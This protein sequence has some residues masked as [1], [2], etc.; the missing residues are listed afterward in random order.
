LILKAMAG[1]TPSKEWYQSRL[2]DLS[3]A[4]GQI[5][6][7]LEPS[8]LGGVLAHVRRVAE[9]K[10]EE[11]DEPVWEPTRLTRI[12]STL[13]PFMALPDGVSDYE[14]SRLQICES[15]PQLLCEGT[16]TGL[17][18]V[19]LGA[20]MFGMSAMPRYSPTA[21]TGIVNFVYCAVGREWICLM[22][23]ETLSFLRGQ[24]P[25][26]S[27]VSRRKGAYRH[28]TELL[29]S[30]R[31][32][33]EQAM[34]ALTVAGVAKHQFGTLR[35]RTLHVVATDMLLRSRG[36]IKNALAELPHVEPFYVS[37]QYS[38]GRFL[39]PSIERFQKLWQSWKA[40]L[41]YILMEA[42]PDL[43]ETQQTL[44]VTALDTLK[45]I[46]P[47]SMFARGLQYSLVYE[48]AW[49]LVQFSESPELMAIYFRRLSYL[50]H[51]V[52]Y[53]GGSGMPEIEL[54]GVVYAAI[55]SRARRD[56]LFEHCPE[57]VADS[58]AD[59][60]GM[61]I[62][63]LK[64]YQYLDQS[65]CEVVLCK[66]VCWLRGGKSAFSAEEWARLKAQVFEEWEHMNS[67]WET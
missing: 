51:G 14:K 21:A 44:V 1:V 50:S 59:I 49:T 9:T 61:L 30:H 55:V 48:L 41:E 29:Q 18:T 28:L 22:V 31:S 19:D 12:Q 24:D 20:A 3:A 36:T 11:F 13:D 53:G 10:D 60:V 47:P 27:L 46:Q 57:E 32:H 35:S 25:G 67:S 23:D 65:G 5:S 54:R 39:I 16:L 52:L 37:G 56:A 6:L 17:D 8:G 45:T 42:R 15:S 7:Y 2:N 63:Q 40:D 43:S 26:K 58:D 38:F 4:N 33:F 66:L 62:N 34:M 64:I